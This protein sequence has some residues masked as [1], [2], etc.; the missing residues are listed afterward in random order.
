MMKAR[1]PKKLLIIVSKDEEDDEVGTMESL[2]D[3]EVYV[4]LDEA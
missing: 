2:G 1:T 4:G 3:N